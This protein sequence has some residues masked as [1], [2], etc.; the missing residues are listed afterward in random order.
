MHDRQSGAM[1]P[2]QHHRY[3]S[4]VV[5]TRVPDSRRAG[6]VINLAAA[7][8]SRTGCCRAVAGGADLR[9][10]TAQPVV[11]LCCAQSAMRA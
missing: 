8:V 10:P 3:L 9:F 2:Q 6:Y 5:A 7:A 11:I 4:V 1:T